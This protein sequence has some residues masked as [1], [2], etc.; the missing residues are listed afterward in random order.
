MT[1][2]TNC[3]AENSSDR[4]QA[5][6]FRHFF[7]RSVQTTFNE[8]CWNNGF[9]RHFP[10]SGRQKALRACFFVAGDVGFHVHALWCNGTVLLNVG[11]DRRGGDG[12]HVLPGCVAGCE[13]QDQVQMIA[14]SDECRVQKPAVSRGGGDDPGKGWLFALGPGDEGLYLGKV[15]EN[16]PRSSG[17]AM[18]QNTCGAS[19]GVGE[20]PRA[21]VVRGDQSRFRG[22]ER[23][24]EFSIAERS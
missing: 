12:D 13:V 4:R 21:A 6:V 8:R 22:G 18:V 1:L 5:E 10:A 17:Y 16:E 2:D 3:S 24:E 7:R 23:H 14:F 19:S 15:A 9:G 11:T 20:Q